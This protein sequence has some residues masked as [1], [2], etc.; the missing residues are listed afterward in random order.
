MDALPD[1]LVLNGVSSSGKSSLARELQALLPRPY[2]VFGV[3]TLVDALP[4]SL[5]AEADGLSF[6]S[7]GAVE[8]GAA[9]TALEDAWY[10]GLAAAAR[11]GA[12]IVL[13][14]VLLGGGR[15]QRRLAAA[16]DG[17]VVC[18]VAVLCDL[19]V[20]AAREAARPDRTPGMAAAQ[21]PLVHADV[22]YDL[23]V[24]TSYDSSS[25]CAQ[26]IVDA[27]GP[28]PVSP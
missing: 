19:D 15:S 28:T 9:F 26:A 23:Q 17:L 10:A 14:E 8:V 7:D 13:D 3:D 4:P 16:L 12:P 18:W 25:A 27:F 2:L 24:D 5:L 11:A 22:V 1:V 6:R 20:A 21:G